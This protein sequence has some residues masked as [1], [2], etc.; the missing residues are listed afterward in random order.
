MT[1]RCR[2]SL[3]SAMVMI[4]GAVIGSGNIHTTG[5]FIS[6]APGGTPPLV[7]NSSDLV[8]NLN[9]DMLDGTHGM[10]FALKTEL[11]DDGV[12]EINQECAVNT[13]C[14]SGDTPGFPVTISTILFE[15]S[16]FRLTSNLDVSGEPTPED[17]TAIQMTNLPGAVIDMNGF[18]IVGPN[19]CTGTSGA[20]LSCTHQ[21]STL[22]DGAGI[23]GGT[24]MTV[25]NGTIRGMGGDGL[26]CNSNCTLIGMRFHFNGRMGGRIGSNSQIL[27]SNFFR[28]FGN[29]LQATSGSTI[30]AATAED[31]AG[32][33]INATLACVI[34]NSTAVDNGDDGIVAA[35]GSLVTESFSGGNAGD[36]IDLQ[37]SFARAN[38][39]RTNGGAGLNMNADS[40]AQDNALWADTLVGGNQMGDNWCG[41]GLCP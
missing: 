19:S 14:F 5:S 18:S 15:T 2:L 12:L 24:G 31:N 26:F 21:S 28:N 3:I 8:P 39:I 41:S 4:P 40:V 20:T 30:E 7:V 27:H 17:A 6:D 33:G 16:A 32:I 1:L 29:G 23:R 34:S 9:A 37:D 38:T 13:G 10:D 36:G 25:L 11:P 35:F 22:S